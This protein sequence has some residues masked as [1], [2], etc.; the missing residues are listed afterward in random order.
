M[1]RV[2]VARRSGRSAASPFAMVHLSFSHVVRISPN[3]ASVIVLPE[4]RTATCAIAS[5]FS[6]MKRSIVRMSRRRAANDDSTHAR[7]AAR[8]RATVAF[9]SSA[10]IAGSVP[11]ASIVHGSQQY[12]TLGCFA[13]SLVSNLGPSGAACVCGS[14]GTLTAP[15]E[16]KISRPELASVAASASAH[17][18]DQ[19]G[20]VHLESAV[21]A[22]MS[23]APAI[24]RSFIFKV[25]RGSQARQ[26]GKHVRGP[27]SSGTPNR[28]SICTSEQ[29]H[30]P[31]GVHLAQRP[32]PLTR[33]RRS[34]RRGGGRRPRCT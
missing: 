6:T 11:S 13:R 32:R 3:A 14:T 8:A 10:D 31:L 9:T 34:A 23:P 19:R 15:R 7:C 25:V 33:R 27:A 16:A 28:C 17:A 30:T 29:R 26:F 20:R 21:P 12:T 2:P 18:E 1:A 4:S 22:A 24:S 5:W